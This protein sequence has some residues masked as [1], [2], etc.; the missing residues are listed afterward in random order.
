MA[1]SVPRSLRLLALAFVT[2]G[3]AAAFSACDGGPAPQQASL[4]PGRT[5]S[6]TSTWSRGDFGGRP[7]SA[8]PVAVSPAAPSGSASAGSVAMDP[9]ALEDLLR[10]VPAQGPAP[11]DPDGGTLVGTAT[12]AGDDGSPITLL[13][14][15][16]HAKKPQ[17]QLGVMALQA[18]MA[19]AAIEREARAQLYF[20]LVTRCRDK[21]GQILPPDAIRLEFTIDDDGYIVPQ[22]ISATARSPEH[23]AAADCMRRE[24]SGLPFRGP[25]GSRGRG[26]QVKMTVPSVD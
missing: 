19:S 13:E 4:A 14:P 3:A 8:S 24:L 18:D 6:P 26:T 1:L 16:T 23:R 10:A 15:P 21:A 7:V 25:A 9:L 20:P 17:I 12:D 2:S 11:T 22:N 5:V